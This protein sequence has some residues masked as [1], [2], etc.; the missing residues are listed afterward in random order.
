MIKSLRALVMVGLSLAFV[1]CAEPSLE[2][3]PADDIG[4]ATDEV[5]STAYRQFV[6]AWDGVE[7]NLRAVV[8]TDTQLSASTRRYFADQVV[9]C[10]RAPCPVVRVEGAFR[11]TASY[12]YLTVNGEVKRYSHTLRGDELTLREGRTVAY[13]FRRATSY[14]ARVSD[15][16]EQQLITPRCLGSF[17]CSSENRCVYR[18]GTAPGTCRTNAECGPASMCAAT[19]C[20]GVGTCRQITVRCGT[21]A[22]PVCG[23]DGVTYTNECMAFTAGQNLA[24]QGACR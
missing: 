20:G 7:G 10:F 4:A 14:C 6:G 8:F 13:R 16:G 18:C 21:Q 19:T 1:G 24:H 5:Q 3:L 17:T 15:C 22:I 23:C 12:L 9:Q 2:E 11:A